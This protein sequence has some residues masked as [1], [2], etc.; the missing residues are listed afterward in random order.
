M[1]K[2]R[3]S[4]LHEKPSRSSKEEI[5]GPISHAYFHAGSKDDLRL[6]EKYMNKALEI[7]PEQH[8]A[9]QTKVHLLIEGKKWQEVLDVCEMALNNDDENEFFIAYQADAHIELKDPT[10]AYDSITRLLAIDSSD[11]DY[12]FLLARYYA[13]IGKNEEA[14][15]KL[16]VGIHLGLELKEETINDSLF[17][18]I[19]T[20]PGYERLLKL[21]DDIFMP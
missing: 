9:L 17:N 21:Q 5:L 18:E 2:R 20:M 4:E 15:D 3:I 19:R 13:L 6:A 7:E 16:I 11:K 12:W 14:I 1:Y 8:E 10:E